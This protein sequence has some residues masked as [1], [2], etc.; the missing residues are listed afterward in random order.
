MSDVKEIKQFLILQLLNSN[1][2][3]IRGKT[4]LVKLMHI[5]NEILKKKKPEFSVYKFYKHHYGPYSD[6]LVKDVEEMISNGLI[7]HKEEYIP[8]TSYVGYVENVYW[9]TEKGKEYL[10]KLA[11]E[12]NPP[13]KILE[14]TQDV[15]IKYNK[16]SLSRLIRIV[17]QEYPIKNEEENNKKIFKVFSF[18][19]T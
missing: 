4:R 19:L 12:I 18:I 3:A 16:I 8:I 6:E 13:E 17:Y 9:I 1:N 5:T 7:G 15:K 14:I 11:N 2:E 10:E